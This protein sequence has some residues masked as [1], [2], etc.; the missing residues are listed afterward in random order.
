[1]YHINFQFFLILSKVYNDVFKEK[2]KTIAMK[3][4]LSDNSEYAMDWTNFYMY[5]I[6]MFCLNAF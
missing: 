4:L 2:L 5:E 1:M 6:R 3:C